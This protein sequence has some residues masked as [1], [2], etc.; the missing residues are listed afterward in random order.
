MVHV[1]R[2]RAGIVTAPACFFIIYTFCDETPYVNQQGGTRNTGLFYM[3]D[4]S[5]TI[6]NSNATYISNLYHTPRVAHAPQVHG[7][8]SGTIRTERIMRNA[9]LT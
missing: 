2:I 9:E 4:A 8:K 1:L 3:A 7:A 5:G 6:H